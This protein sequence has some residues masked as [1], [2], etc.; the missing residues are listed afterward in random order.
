MNSNQLDYKN[1]EKYKKNNGI[2]DINEDIDEDL[3]LLGI[4]NELVNIAKEI[5]E[6]INRSIEFYSIKNRGES[7]KNLYITGGTSLLKGIKKMISEETDLEPEFIKP[8]AGMEMS[9]KLKSKF[10]KKIKTS[11]LKRG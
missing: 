9:D 5:V 4:S 11:N 6:E 7:I 2:N 3:S 10:A 8:F 1:A